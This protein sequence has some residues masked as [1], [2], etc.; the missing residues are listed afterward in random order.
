MAVLSS[1]FSP[2]VVATIKAEKASRYKVPV[3]MWRPKS[4]AIKGNI[5][6]VKHPTITIKMLILNEK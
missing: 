3:W 5:H 2:P 6:G 4:M 1:L